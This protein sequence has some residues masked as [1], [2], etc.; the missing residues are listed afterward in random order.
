M[1]KASLFIGI[2]G[3]KSL[4]ARVN[5]PGRSDVYNV[6]VHPGTALACP[7]TVYLTINYLP[8]VQGLHVQLDIFVKKIWASAVCH[9]P[10]WH[11]Y[12]VQM[13]IFSDTSC[14][15][16]L[17]KEKIDYSLKGET[18]S[19]RNYSLMERIMSLK[20][21]L[22]VTLVVVNTQ[23]AIKLRHTYDSGISGSN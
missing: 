16:F 10:F 14:G 3:G 19:D 9:V 1:P 12:C 18:W 5:W 6:H 15:T 7:L 17:P 4:N 2:R 22:R 11:K 20:T 8:D 13:E 21:D 23:S